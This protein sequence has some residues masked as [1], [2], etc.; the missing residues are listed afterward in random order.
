MSNFID[1]EVITNSGE[2][3][4][5]IPVNLDCVEI[6]QEEKDN[7]LGSTTILKMRTTSI[8]ET[9]A[10]RSTTPYIEIKSH[11]RIGLH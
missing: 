10:I 5:N 2:I 6:I 1:I 3:H 4:G 8:S 7:K 11:M 9:P